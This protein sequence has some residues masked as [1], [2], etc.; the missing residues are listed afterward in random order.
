M[1]LPTPGIGFED[2]HAPITGEAPMYGIVLDYGAP[3]PNS[4]RLYGGRLVN[5]LL[6]RTMHELQGVVLAGEHG[7][8]TGAPMSVDLTD[9]D[10]LAQVRATTGPVTEPLY[11]PRWGSHVLVEFVDGLPFV[12]TMFADPSAPTAVN[13]VVEPTASD[14]D[15]GAMAADKAEPA[16][17]VQVPDRAPPTPI[18]LVAHAEN[19][20]Y[21]I[22]EYQSK[23]SEARHDAYLRGAASGIEKDELYGAGED[24]TDPIV[25]ASVDGGYAG[26]LDGEA[27][28]LE[29]RSAASVTAPTKPAVD[30]TDPN[31]L[32]AGDAASPDGQAVPARA[33]GNDR[34]L[35]H[36]P[37]GSTRFI[38]H[39]DG[40]VTIDNRTS[41]QPIRIQGDTLIFTTGN[42]TQIVVDAATGEVRLGTKGATKR[43]VF[44]E[45]M[46]TLWDGH[47]HVDSV[48]GMT[49][50]PVVAMS[51]AQATTKV[52]AV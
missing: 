28:G 21:Y 29:E 23:W 50:V 8:T 51:A 49:Q 37:D 3:D 22:A 14:P 12:R 34:I 18:V 43:L 31:P 30:W 9:A 17:D 11:S 6:T 41:G 48:G 2:F 5:V 27:A 40:S 26:I 15:V 19:A 20:E 52:K 36:G 32:G 39:A 38:M 7:R 10:L 16:A 44:Y 25:T 35:Y 42:G 33:T 13:P 24:R 1:S 47:T 4:P 45:D 46:K